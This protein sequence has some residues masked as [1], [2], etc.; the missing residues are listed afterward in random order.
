MKLAYYFKDFTDA[1]IYTLDDLKHADLCEDD[2][3]NDFSVHSDR[4]RMK[5]LAAIRKL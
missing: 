5:I 1:G 2:L 3:E 4:E